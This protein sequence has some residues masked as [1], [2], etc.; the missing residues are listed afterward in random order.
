SAEF[1]RDAPEYRSRG[2]EETMRRA[3]I[4]MLVLA[5]GCGSDKS[6]SGGAAVGGGGGGA[7]GGAGARGPPGRGGGGGAS[8]GAPCGN[9]SCASDEICVAKTPKG[10]ECMAVPDGGGCPAGTTRT[11]DCC[12]P[13]TTTYVCQPGSPCMGDNPSCCA[14][15]KDCGGCNAAGSRISC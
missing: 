14:V 4:L 9:K 3:L 2:M 5:A 8:S 10:P 12:V 11:G 7:R 6:G 15:C 13:D 1:S